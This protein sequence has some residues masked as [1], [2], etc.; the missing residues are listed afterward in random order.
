M[1]GLPVPMPE[2]APPSLFT[3]NVLY[4]EIV[5]AGVRPTVSSSVV[6]DFPVYFKFSS[7]KTLEAS[8]GMRVAIVTIFYKRFDYFE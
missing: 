6:P 1:F 7:T 8:S 5:P 2:D 3:T 4:Q